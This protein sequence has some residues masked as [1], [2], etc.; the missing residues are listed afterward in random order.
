MGDAG[1]TTELCWELVDD[2]DGDPVRYRVWVDGIEL[3]EGKLETE[4]GWSGP[5][6][7]PLNFNFDQIYAWRVSAFNPDYPI[8]DE[9]GVRTGWESESASSPTW[10]FRTAAN[11]LAT[12]LFEDDFEDDRG[13]TVDGDADGGHWVLGNPAPAEFEGQVSQPGDCAGQS[14]CYFTGVNMEG[15]PDMQDVR[16]GTTVLTSPPIDMSGVATATIQL[17]RFF[18][19]SEFPETG[20][21]FRVE[22]VVPDRSAP[23]QERTYVLEQLESEGS[24]VGANMWTPREYSACGVPM[25]DGAR[26]RV[27]ATDLGEG[28]LEAAID[29]V[30][31]TGYHD[32]GLC[33]GGVGSICDPSHDAACADALLCCADG[34]VNTGVYRCMNPVPGLEYPVASTGPGEPPAGPLGCNAPD[35]FPTADGMSVWEDELFVEMDSCTLFEG[36]VGAPGW[37]QLLRFDTITPNSG[38]RDLIMG[39][40]SN[41][42]DLFHFSECHQHYHFDGY[43]QYQLLDGE[44]V[45]ATGHKQAFCL[46]D[47][48]SWAWPGDDNQ[49][50]CVNQGIQNG[51]QDIYGGLLDCNW[52]DVTGVPPG[53]YTLRISINPPREDTAVAP[54]VERDYT[55]NVLDVAVTLSG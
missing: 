17:S 53:E 12:V 35:L 32:A 40:P 45:V 14:G 52:I 21:L 24:T 15:L 34:T 13:W 37:R 39:V 9:L 7:G 33:D 50:T 44:D 1:V 42:P 48:N 27:I 20:T 41:H 47:W 49:Y 26:L 28:I 25:R 5:C 29:N 55:N 2:P 8:L 31:V 16:G 10:G 22:I 51:W 30:V 36:C 3:S 23:T 18:F 46:L 54:L 43:A 6:L 19:K 38:S 11:G 4:P